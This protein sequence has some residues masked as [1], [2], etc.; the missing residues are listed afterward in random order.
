MNLAYGGNS[1]I[2]VRFVFELAAPTYFVA[3]DWGSL[4]KSD[5]LGSEE[6]F[7][8]MMTGKELSAQEYRQEIKKI[9]PTCLVGEDSVP[10]LIGY[11][12][13]D[14]CVPADQKEYLIEHWKR[15]GYRMIMIEFHHSNHLLYGD[16]DKA[17]IYGFILGILQKIFSIEKSRL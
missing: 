11:G 14:H 7:Y 2:P 4:M 17:D 5:N 13:K 16:L 12:L 9:S 8:R 15:M 1:A 6:E 3:E 10:T